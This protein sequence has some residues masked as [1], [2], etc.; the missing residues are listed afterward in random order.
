MRHEQFV[1]VKPIDSGDIPLSGIVPTHRLRRSVV[2]LSMAGT[3]TAAS[4]SPCAAQ[5]ILNP[6]SGAGAQAASGNGG[7]GGSN[8]GGGAGGSVGAS[9]GQVGTLAQGGNGAGATSCDTKP[10]L[11]GCG[12]KTGLTNTPISG[13]AQGG[14]AVAALRERSRL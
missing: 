11:A 3:I 7:S 1:H 13:N 14:D 2:L 4:V 10:Y 6:G 12:G 5:V 8:N 9:A